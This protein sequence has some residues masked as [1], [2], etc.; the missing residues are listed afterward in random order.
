LVAATKAACFENLK[1]HKFVG[2]LRVSTYNAMPK[3]GVETLV[4]FLK[5]YKAANS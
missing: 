5:E 3:E 1:G 4:K 2:G